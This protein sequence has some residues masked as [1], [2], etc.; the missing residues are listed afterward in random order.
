VRNSG[1]AGQIEAE[2]L[3]DDRKQR[4]DDVTSC[5]SCGQS[6]KYRTGRGELNGR[7][8]SKR[9]QHGMTLGTSVT[10]RTGCGRKSTTGLRCYR[11]P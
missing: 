1:L 10:R 7:F 4:R 2:I 3:R 11:G 6:F 5:W 9:C 8:C